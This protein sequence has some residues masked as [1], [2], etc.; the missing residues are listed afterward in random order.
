MTVGPPRSIAYACDVSAFLSPMCAA[1]HRAMTGG[2]SPVV[3]AS[4]GSDTD[5]V[6]SGTNPWKKSA[7]VM[8]T[9]EDLSVVSVGVHGLA[10]IEPMAREVLSDVGIDIGA[11]LHNFI[12]DIDIR[13]K[14]FDAPR[15]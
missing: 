1:I 7:V 12:Q 15:L 6:V 14:P 5:Q 3:T 11:L 8:A 9:M 10:K 2:V 4:I 13:G